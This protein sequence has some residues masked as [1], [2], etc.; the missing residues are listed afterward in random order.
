MTD[1]AARAYTRADQEKDTMTPAKQAANTA[2]KFGSPPYPYELGGW[3]RWHI[4]PVAPWRFRDRIA[5]LLGFHCWC[6]M[7]FS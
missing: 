6:C 3:H 2:S 5:R 4:P 1:S 7:R